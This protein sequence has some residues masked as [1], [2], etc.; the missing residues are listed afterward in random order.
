MMKLTVLGCGDAF[1][2]EGRFNTSF[3][4]EHDNEKT[5]VDCG[6][7][8]L[9]RLKQLKVP[10][11]EINTVVISHFHG[12]HYGGLPFLFLSNHVEYKRE[13]PLTV[14]G[15]GGVRERVYELQE[16]LYPGTSHVIDSLDIEFKEFQDQHWLAHEAMEV[17]A[18]R[19]TH[20]PPSNPHGIKLKLAGKTFVFSGDTEWNESL[21]DLADGADLFIVECNNFQEESPGHLSYTTIMQR[22]EDF[23]AKQIFLTHMGSTLIGQPSLKIKRLEDGMQIDF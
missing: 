7:S 18:R 15:P 5:L 2:S 21:V 23:N 12:D 1:A 3:L 13:T 16:A 8:T 17:Y 14:I 19:V 4:L 22:L 6:A 10:V 20:A 9:V 11:S